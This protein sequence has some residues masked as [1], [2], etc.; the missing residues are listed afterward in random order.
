MAWVKIDDQFADHPKASEAGP[1]GIAMQVAG[2]CYANRHLTDGFVSVSVARRLLDFTGLAEEMLN[3]HDPD[4][5]H[6]EA[7]RINHLWV[8][9]KLV[10]AGLWEDTEGGWQI[11]DYLEYNPS[12]ADTLAKRAADLERKK[13]PQRPPA[14]SA[15]NPNGIHKDSKRPVPDPVPVEESRETAVSLA[16]PSSPR[17][18]A[19]DLRLVRPAPKPKDT[20]QPVNPLWDA[21]VEGIGITPTTTNE[22]SKYGKV[23]RELR[24]LGATPEEI[25]RRC[26]NYMQHWPAVDLTPTALLEHWSRMDKPPNQQQARAPTQADHNSARRGKLVT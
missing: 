1:L 6:V 19:P 17:Q 8:I 4:D 3:D 12:R 2:L 23:V 15:R 25:R 5:S 13:N 10:S 20:P 24:D 16:A 21:L 11:H 22:R 9:E 14:N 26:A 18:E 7:F